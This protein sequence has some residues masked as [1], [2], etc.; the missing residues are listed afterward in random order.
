[1]NGAYNNEIEERG[2]LESNLRASL[3]A[4]LAH[5]GTRHGLEMSA[6]IKEFR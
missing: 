5:Y 1:M 2:Q 6:F 4:T 3:A